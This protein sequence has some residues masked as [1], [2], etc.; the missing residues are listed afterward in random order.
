VLPSW[1][2]WVNLLYLPLAFVVSLVLQGLLAAVIA[3][4][5]DRARGRHWTE[6]ARRTFPLMSAGRALSLLLCLLFGGL[7]AVSAGPLSHLGPAFLVPALFAAVLAGSFWPSWRLRRHLRAVPPPASVWLRTYVFA[8]LLGSPIYVALFLG[9]LFPPRVDVSVVV[10]LAL[11]AVFVVFINVGGITRLGRWLGLLVPPSPRLA[12]VAADAAAATGVRLRSVWLA[13]LGFANAFALPLS[14]QVI[15]TEP[16]TEIFDDPELMAVCAHEL[17]HV[18]EGPWTRLSRMWVGLAVL[19]LAAVR[20]LYGSFGGALAVLVFACILVGLLLWPAIARRLERRS[21][22]T[23]HRHEVEPGT[24]ARALEKLYAQELMPAVGHG[25]G[26]SHPH[27]YDRLVAAGVTPEYPRPAPPPRWLGAGVFVGLYALMAPI[28]A[29]IGVVATLISHTQSPSLLHFSIGAFGRGSAALDQLAQV[30]WA[31]EHDLE[32]AI[33]LERLAAKLEPASGYYPMRVADYLALAG[34][35]AESR[36]WV[37]EALAPGKTPALA[38]WA[39]HASLP[40]E[41]W[42]RICGADGAGD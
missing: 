13:R 10:G 1:V 33:D 31:K 28:A 2:G 22:E 30:R 4:A 5:H 26:G 14:R 3:A 27:L 29:A 37:T 38:R 7:A 42:E 25:Q 23:A 12:R 34:R 6:R 35:C 17:G 16:A 19:S 18:G 24:Y 9:C 20:P 36:P 41:D 15:V 21:D 32:A 39:R 8:V 40:G 11:G